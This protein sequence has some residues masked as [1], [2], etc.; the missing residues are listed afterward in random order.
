MT[1]LENHLEEIKSRITTYFDCEGART[2]GGVRWDMVAVSHRDMQRYFLERHWVVDKYRTSEWHFYKLIPARLTEEQIAELEQAL[3]KA[4][5]E[6][7]T[8]GFHQMETRLIGVILTS[9]MPSAESQRRIWKFRKRH[10]FWLGLKGWVILEMAL[11]AVDDRQVVP[12]KSLRGL[13]D[14]LK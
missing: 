2:I 14:L 12:R 1:E 9:H 6:L 8:P 7:V 11:V 13:Q 5:R 4:W 10:N 3:E